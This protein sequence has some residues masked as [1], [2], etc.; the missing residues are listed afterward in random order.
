M[1]YTIYLFDWCY[2]QHMVS[3]QNILD[4]AAIA[5][6]NGCS[7]LGDI[8]HSDYDSMGRLKYFF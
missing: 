1:A 7:G 4:M 2:Q 3:Q 6:S 5:L 8:F